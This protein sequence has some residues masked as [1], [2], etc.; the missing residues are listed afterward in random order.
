MKVV[1]VAPPLVAAAA[2][3][4][5]KTFT[6]PSSVQIEIKTMSKLLWLLS[7]SVQLAL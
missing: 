3:K 7:A 4:Q 1:V 2:R 5:A 6:L